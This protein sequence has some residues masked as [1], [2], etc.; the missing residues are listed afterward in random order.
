MIMIVIA[1]LMMGG[2]LQLRN[3]NKTYLFKLL[4]I[5]IELVAQ[6]RLGLSE[7]KHLAIKLIRSSRFGLRGLLLLLIPGHVPLYLNLL[8]AHGRVEME[9]S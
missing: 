1:L 9:L 4:N 3:G 7:G 2:D 5:N 8:G 6:L